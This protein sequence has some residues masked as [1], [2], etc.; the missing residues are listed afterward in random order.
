MSVLIARTLPPPPLPCAAVK[1]KKVGPFDSRPP[2]LLLLQRSVQTP[3]RSGRRKRR[4]EVCFGSFFSWEENCRDACVPGHTFPC[5]VRPIVSNCS[6]NKAGVD[7]VAFFL[8]VHRGCRSRPTAVIRPPPSVPSEGEPPYRFAL[9][10]L[11]LPL[12]C[13][14]N[15]NLSHAFGGAKN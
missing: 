8:V 10:S 9:F 4:E 11:P 14:L 15:L 2:L 3:Q 12:H 6:R 13:R 5:H 1:R 7:L